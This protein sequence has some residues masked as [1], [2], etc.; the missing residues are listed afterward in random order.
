MTINNLY[1]ETISLCPVCAKDSRAFYEEKQGEM[2]LHV[3]CN[4]HGISCEKVESDSRFFKQGYE[5]EYTKPYKH[6]FLPITY[7]CNLRCKFCYIM[8]NS[9]L[10]LP[11]D[12][13]FDKLAAIMK[14]FDGNV[15]FV[16]GEPTVRNDMMRLVKTAKEMNG[17][18]KISISTNGQKLRDIEYV[19]RLKDCG[20]DFVILSFNDI[21]FEVSKVIY[22]RKVDA[23]HNCHEL[24]IPVWLQRTV[25]RLDQLKSITDVLETYRKV[26]FSATIRTVRP[27][28]ITYPSTQVFVSDMLKY[29]EKEKNYSK[30][31]SPF[32]RHICLKGKNVKITSWINDMKRYDPIDSNYIISND[33]FTTF[34]RGMKMDEVLLLR[35]TFYMIN[36]AP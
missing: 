2:F 26:I 7:R 22:R 18:R 35:K 25:E 36:N 13:S 3:E 10:Q 34:H 14:N 6:L 28:G 27:Y 4:E 15:T 33:I 24:R 11:E 9:P 32:S 29:F 1:T 17:K 20:I 5:Q 16:G 19:K 12:R 30:G 31:T 23:L 8:S 21:E